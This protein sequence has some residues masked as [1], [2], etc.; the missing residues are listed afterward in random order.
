MLGGNDPYSAS[1]AALEIAVSSWRDSFCVNKEK[2][3][4]NLKIATARAG[5]VIGGGDWAND[6]IVPDAIR[7]IIKKDS[8]LLRNPYSTRPWQHVLEPLWGYILL[9]KF[10]YVD[11]STF[12]E[13]F[14]FGPNISSNRQVKDVVEKIF[15]YWP[16]KYIIQKEQNTYH[17]AVRLNL[18]VDKAFQKLNWFPKMDFDI[19][20]QKTVKW[21]KD[22]SE[23]KCQI[24]CCLD[25]IN[26]Y[27]NLI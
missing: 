16:G 3:S 5:N 6:R 27:Q 23:G 10:L 13:S 1:K 21:Y 17:E 18:N 14:N 4:S 19:T 26:F 25:D 20:I 7:S 11:G 15:D 12:S 2:I 24:E 8:L 9:A 22:S